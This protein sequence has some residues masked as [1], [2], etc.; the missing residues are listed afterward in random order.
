V[1]DFGKWRGKGLTLPQIVLRDPDW[2]FWAAKE[3][4]FPAALKDEAKRIAYRATHITINKPGPTEWEIEYLV[5]HDGKFA[6]F[7]IVPKDRPRHEGSSMAVRSKHLS[8]AFPSSLKGYDKLGCRLMLAGFKYHGL[9]KNGRFTK[10][11][12]EAFFSEAS[13][14]A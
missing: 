6:N 10:Q 11:N 12:C 13:H 5:G 1:V 9:G 14:F 3:D 4:V 8:L 2:F 7:E